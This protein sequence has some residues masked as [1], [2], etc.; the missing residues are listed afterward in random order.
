MRWASSMSD[1][2]EL[3]LALALAANDLDASL[4]AAKPDVLLAFVSGEHQARMHVLPEWLRDRWSSAVVLGCSA[5]GVVAKG[6]EHERGPGLV[7]AAASLPGVE[8]TPFHLEQVGELEHDDDPARWRERIGL[9]AGPD[10][11][12][13]LLPDPFTWPGPTLLEAIDRAFPA[14]IKIGGLASGGSRAGEHR[15]FADRSVHLRGTVGLAMRG[16]LELDTIVAQ[17]CRPIGQPMFVTRHHRNVIAELDGRSALEALQDLFESLEP[18]DR[19]R[20]RH[21]LFLG[22][23]VARG[24]APVELHGR[25]DFLI[26]NLIGVDPQTGALAVAAPISPNSVVQFHLRDGQ[27]AAVELRELLDEHVEAQPEPPSGALLFSCLGRGRALY[28]QPD[29]DSQALQ[30]RFGGELPI[31][32]FFCNGE[33]GPVAGR[34]HLHGYTSAIALFRAATMV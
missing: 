29:H 20:A 6:R 17:G 31:A 25:G 28:G 14:G 30:G 2:P 11:H 22:V 24:D 3:E 23:V 16:N 9:S 8:L 19:T 15:L 5:G 18:E 1:A 7:L 32:G 12:I 27:T 26:R 10:P 4:A 13:V 21:S 34:T 33:I